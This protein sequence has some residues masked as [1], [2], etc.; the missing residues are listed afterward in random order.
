MTAPLCQHPN[1]T[2]PARWRIEGKD[3]GGEV[4]TTTLACDRCLDVARW[5]V[6][7]RENYI[8]LVSTRLLTKDEVTI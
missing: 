2:R 8:V 5:Q 1:C 6:W 4:L 7:T 3:G